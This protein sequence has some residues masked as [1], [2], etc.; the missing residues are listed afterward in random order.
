MYVFTDEASCKP[1]FIA[2]GETAAFPNAKAGRTFLITLLRTTPDTAVQ[3]RVQ[4]RPLTANE[5]GT[6]C[7]P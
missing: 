4:R 2:V 1:L 6:D 5:F 3:V 7:G